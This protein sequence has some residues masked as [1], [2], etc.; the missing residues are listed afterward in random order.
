MGI[1]KII[2]KAETEAHAEILDLVGATKIVFPN[3]EAAKRITPLMISSSL[4]NYLP[5]SGSLVI[6]EIEIP[7]SI[8]G[9]TLLESN[10]RKQYAI[11][12]ISVKNGV[13]EEY[14][15][16]TPE[17]IFRPGDIA[18]VSGT[19]SALDAFTGRISRERVSVVQ[20]LKRLFGSPKN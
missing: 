2:V 7:E 3:R 14:G 9:K 19:N 5:V 12:L 6:A 8:L 16:F 4:L 15:L 20:S 17:Y 1:T 13:D 18:L 11:N 10:L